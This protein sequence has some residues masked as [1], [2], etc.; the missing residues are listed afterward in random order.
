MQ[1]L[2]ISPQEAARQLI[3]R[4]TV[5]RNLT[6]WCKLIGFQPAPHHRLIIKEIEALLRSDTYD[7]LL[8]F[9][10]P[11]SAKSSYVSVALPSW[12]LASHPKNSILAASH[13][14]T[15]AEK[16][17][18]RVRNLVGEHATTLGIQLAA[19]SQ[20]ASRWSL[21]QGG[22]Y[23]AAGVGVGIAGFRADLG[24]ID[25]PIGSRE[26]AFSELIREKLWDW[27]IND[28]SSRLKP[29][30]KRVVMHTRW[31]EDDP[32]GRLIDAAKQGKYKIRVL[33]LPAIAKEN[34]P[35]GRK[36]GEWLWD[37]PKGYN[38]A[39][40]LKARHLEVPP[41][42]WSALYQQEPTP[43][44]GDYFKREW[45]NWYDEVPKHLT[46]YGASDYAVTAKGGDYTVHGVAGV[47]PDNNLYVV[48]VWRQQTATN[49]WIEALL[50]MAKQYPTM[51]WAEESGQIVKGVGPFI[52]QRQRERK[53]YFRREEFVSIA[54]K[55]TRCRSFQARAA[56]RKVYLPRNAPWLDDFLRELHSFPAGKTDD[57][58][59]TMGLIGRMLDEMIGARV[60]AVA[61]PNH[62]ADYGGPG[63]DA[64]EGWKVA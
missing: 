4:R 45:W 43:D 59:D 34:D 16:W 38:Y 64:E 36:P 3:Q 31:H 17:G 15:L 41:F 52:T 62:V 54:D 39:A 24:I 19:D 63:D 20:A 49:L 55:P 11:G 37:E 2:N 12:Y 18:R 51:C 35:L 50:D 46:Y 10:P 25:D 53:V 6:E 14:T 30:A 21:E 9:A 32:A 1:S 7:T 29:S 61:E 27:F 47:D 48:D 56:M 28:F 26:Q 5:R 58:V 40:F 33:S 13:T 60:P 44:D 42:E 23:Q 57:Q 8:I 22:E